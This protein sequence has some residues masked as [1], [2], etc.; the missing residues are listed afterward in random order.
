MPN[1]TNKMAIFR[2][3]FVAIFLIICCSKSCISDSFNIFECKTDKLIISNSHIKFSEVL[4]ISCPGKFKA[5]EIYAW[6][7]ITIDS[8]Y[9]SLGLP[10]QLSIIAPVIEVIGHR[11]IILNGA[12]GKGELHE[13]YSPSVGQGKDGKPGKPGTSS[14]SIMM[15]AGFFIGSENCTIELNGGNGARGQD[16]GNGIELFFNQ[17]NYVSLYS[18]L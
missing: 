9:N 11:K 18:K 2:I 12:P 1:S 10:V 3:N 13:V 4:D 16:G 6:H 14:G 8:D 17:I 5:I 7:E 15:I